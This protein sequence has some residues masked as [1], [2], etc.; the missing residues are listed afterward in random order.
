[1]SNRTRPCETADSLDRTGLRNPSERPIA[2]L[3]WRGISHRPNLIW[4][5][6]L[7]ETGFIDTIEGQQVQNQRKPILW[8]GKVAICASDLQM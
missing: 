2:R 5:P 3:R 7:S 8:N 6:Y 1:M 4:M